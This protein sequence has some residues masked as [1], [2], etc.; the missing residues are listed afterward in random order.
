MLRVRSVSGEILVSIEL[1]IFLGT[2]PAENHPV[3]AL[4]QHLHN[5]CGQPRF[6][7][8]LVFLDEGATL[9][10]NDEHSLKPGDA[11]LVL[12]NFSSASEAQIQDLRRAA[13]RGLTSVVETILHKPQDPN[14]GDPTPLLEACHSGHLE[15]ARLLLEAN[16][17]KDKAMHDGATP[18]FLA[19]T[20]GHLE[21]ARLLLQ[22]NADKDKATDD[23]ATPLLMA[24]EKEHLENARLLLEAN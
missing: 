17:D 14:L 3:L 7:Q 11:Q 23:G 10:D 6:R 5:L 9:N 18:L 13:E 20:T 24:A 15:V 22:A 4:K 2:L 1:E 21:S 8:R 16:A 19:A 12:V